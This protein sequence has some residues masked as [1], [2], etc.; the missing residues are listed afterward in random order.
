MILPGLSSGARRALAFATALLVVVSGTSCNRDWQ[1][2]DG[3][4]L[5]QQGALAGEPARVPVEPGSDGLLVGRSSATSGATDPG[6]GQAARP[7]S[8]VASRPDRGALLEYPAPRTSRRQGAYTW[9]RV[10]LSEEHA[11]RALASGVLRIPA[12]DGRLLEFKSERHV[13]HSSGDW[14]W[15]G[16]LAGRAD[17]QHA[18]LTFGADAVFGSIPQ[19][20]AL[21][22]RLAMRDG[23]SWLVE[24]D[25]GLEAD[26]ESRVLHPE[27]P[28]FLIP[29]ALAMAPP[30]PAA[31]GGQPDETGDRVESSSSTSSSAGVLVDV[32]VGYTPGFAAYWGG[33]SQALTRINN[34]VEVGNQ[35]FI[36]S[37]VDARV[38]LVHA[39]Q[40]D[41]PDATDNGETLEKLTGYKSGSGTTVSDP[42]FA[43]LRDARETYGADLV[44]LVRKFN[45]P[46][47][48]G[49]GIAWLIGGGLTTISQGHEY[50]GYSVV[51]DGQDQGSDGKTYFCR[52][53]TMVHEFGHNMGSAHDK[54]NAQDED[55]Q[56]EYG[57]YAYSF[58]YKTDAS[59]GDFYTIMAYRDKRDS[60]PQQ[61]AYRVF[62]NPRITICGGFACGAADAD[63]AR[64]LNQTA[65]VIANFR[66][67]VVP[68]EALRV[69]DD[70][71]GD[72]KS[73]LLFRYSSA[74]SGRFG[75]WAMD[76]SQVKRTWSLETGLK[77]R[78]AAT[79]DFDGDG[80]LDAAWTSSARDVKIWFGNG[81]SFSSSVLAG[82][83]GAGWEITGSGDVDGDGKSDIL[84][85]YQSSGSGK[86]GYWAMDGARVKRTW[87]IET[88]LTYRVAATGDFNGDG[89]LDLAWTSD[90]R[91]IK[92]WF[93]NGSSFSKSVYAGAYSAGWAVIG[94]GDVDGDGRDDL[95]F[96]Y[97]SGTSGKFGYWAMGGA[98]VKRTWSVK[99]G[100]KYRVAA[101]GDYNGDGLLDIAWTSDSRDVQMWFGN[102]ISFSSS[103]Y[104]GSYS[105]GWS[106]IGP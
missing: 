89:L 19:P 68:I 22:L 106:I 60:G 37:Q 70:I 28:D 7:A 43:A 5:A 29:P 99:T 97:L 31:A 1:E 75:Y 76:G 36:N 93:G 103:A 71:D 101:M 72:G 18:I 90:A 62:S 6:S 87:S 33:T 74:T 57:R 32:L 35:G 45:D 44:T 52:E 17:A 86:F 82:S 102:G 12:P 47:N 88:G 24:T 61:T 66:A 15:V 92:M 25:P 98:T 48:D 51:S 20:D 27:E 50:F 63:N 64:S 95:V 55:G 41:Y 85:R 21:P 40:V 58:G 78:V 30:S 11:W 80:L 46:E 3:L 79:G 38:R 14:T 26:A 105:A 49:C 13:E 69:K 77:Y 59:A 53:E 73:D 2:R 83:Y 4:Y 10:D 8:S 94:S 65:P 16:R 54:E 9:H 23:K 56:Q 34:L 67:Q 81:T 42:A 104:A 39:M 91:D 100:V 96:R 84:F